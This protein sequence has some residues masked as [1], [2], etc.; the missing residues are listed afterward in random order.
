MTTH[1]LAAVDAPH[2][3]VRMIRL[4]PPGMPTVAQHASLSID[5]NTIDRVL[6]VGVPGRSSGIPRTSPREGRMPM[7]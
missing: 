5:C 4:V 3:E 2:P 6:L 1:P 7:R